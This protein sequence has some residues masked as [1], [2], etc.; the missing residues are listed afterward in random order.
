MDDRLTV[1]LLRQVRL[2]YADR[3]PKLRLGCLV[4]VWLTHGECFCSISL[5][6]D[7]ARLIRTPVSN[8]ENGS[9]SSSSAPL[10]AS[11]FPERD[12]TCHL[13]V[14]ENSDDGQVLRRPLGYR[15]GYPLSGVMTL[16]NFADGGYDVND[17]KIL[18]VVKSIGA[19]KTGTSPHPSASKKTLT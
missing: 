3:M 11:L 1:L 15:K 2:W 13:M 18:V 14:H 8:G 10:F 4:S 5:R 19:K 16:Q 12:R 17:A 7:E 6:I 9:L